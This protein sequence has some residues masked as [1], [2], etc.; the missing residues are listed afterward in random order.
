MSDEKAAEAAE[1]AEAAAPA[2]GGTSWLKLILA[3]IVA[4]VA[5]RF[6]A[7]AVSPNSRLEE[8][9]EQVGD[10]SDLGFPVE[11]SPH[12]HHPDENSEDQ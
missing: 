6:A 5:L 8:M 2:K 4:I 7:I 11:P 1:A 10:T 12:G 9:L 3:V